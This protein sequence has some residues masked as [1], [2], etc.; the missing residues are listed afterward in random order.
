MLVRLKSPPNP[1]TGE[2]TT[3]NYIQLIQT[4]NIRTETDAYVFVSNKGL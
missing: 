3:S 4:P 2:V 1:T